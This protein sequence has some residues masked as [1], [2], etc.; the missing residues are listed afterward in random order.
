MD[1][2]SAAIEYLDETAINYADDMST[3]SRMQNVK[4]SHLE[5]AALMEKAAKDHRVKPETRSRA[6]RLARNLRKLDAY[7]KRKYGKES[8]KMDETPMFID[9]PSPFAPKTELLTSLA[10]LKKMDQNN[11]YVR[12]AI[13][14]VEQ[15]LE[16]AKKNL[17]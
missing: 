9:I 15:N 7:L 13:R 12:E 16:I 11:R 14:E 2:G 8:V 6:A 1:A 17:A 4:K 5:M 10:N 3:D